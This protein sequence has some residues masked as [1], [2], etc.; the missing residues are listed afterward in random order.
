MPGPADIGTQEPQTPNM[1]I[2]V[3]STDGVFLR[4]KPDISAK[5]IA[6]IPFGS[7]VMTE[8]GNTLTAQLDGVIAKWIPVKWS[9][10]TGFVFDHYVVADKANLLAGRKFSYGVECSGITYSEFT[11]HLIF[12][13]KFQYRIEH[14]SEFNM[15]CNLR[16]ISNGTYEL[17][18]DKLR[19][20]PQKIENVFIGQKNCP[21]KTPIDVV[22]GYDFVDGGEYLVTKCG[23]KIAFS[24]DIGNSQGFVETKHLP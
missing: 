18:G 22:K 13:E 17:T 4:E 9:G 19:L 23:G 21:K 1:V 15:G 7:E 11:W 6:L 14:L 5:K 20:T 3:A 2:Y 8:N 10:K 16:H 12:L 24:K